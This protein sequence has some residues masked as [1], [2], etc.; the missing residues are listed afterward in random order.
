MLVGF[1]NGLPSD[2]MDALTVRDFKGRCEIRPGP[3]YLLRNYQ[4]TKS[5]FHLLQ[6][7]YLDDMCTVP[8]FSV[9]AWG[10]YFFR[11]PSMVVPG[12]MD[13]DYDLRGVDIMAYKNGVVDSL[14]HKINRSCPGH[15]KS[16]WRTYKKYRLYG[17]TAT[18][19]QSDQQDIDCLAGL[20]LT[21]NE[22]QL[23]RVEYRKKLHRGH[24]QRKKSIELFLGDIHTQV[25]RR[26]YYRP[27]RYQP[28]LSKQR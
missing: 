10:H 24:R 1:W 2:V 13:V 11:R 22:L 9:F 25:H 3:E 5:R 21:F 19:E 8:A 16:R 15:L 12:G 20:H 6:Y 26:A 28:P 7:Y 18:R 17:Y 4:F 23:M 27:T 14:R